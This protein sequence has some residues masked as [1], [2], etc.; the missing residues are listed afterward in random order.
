MYLTCTPPS[1]I[2]QA[3]ADA[4]KYGITNIVALRGDAPEGE[5]EWKKKEGGF[6]CARDLVD[7][8]K[9]EYGDEVS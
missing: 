5:G 2:P 8:I 7:F 1:L 4:R 6:E 3:L 9:R